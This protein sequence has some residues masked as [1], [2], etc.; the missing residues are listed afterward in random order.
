MLTKNKMEN[1]LNKL[2]DFY[3][4]IL[5]DSLRMFRENKKLKDEYILMDEITFEEKIQDIDDLLEYAEYNELYEECSVL[6]DMKNQI[7]INNK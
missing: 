3:D 1:K 4:L 2:I 5:L 6:A 7:I